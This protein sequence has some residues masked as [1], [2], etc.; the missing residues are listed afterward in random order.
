M[1]I[2]VYI[3]RALRA[4]A[5]AYRIILRDYIT[6]VYYGIILRD[7]IMGLYYRIILRD[8]ITGLNG[9]SIS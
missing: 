3:K 4:R 5:M 2:Y 1:Y 7:Y 6:G 8:H 9:G